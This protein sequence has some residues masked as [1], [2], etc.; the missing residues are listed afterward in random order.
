MR[1]FPFC[2]VLQAPLIPSSELNR[3]DV[4][5]LRP[6]VFS[7]VITLKSWTWNEVMNLPID[8]LA[9]PRSFVFLWCGLGGGVGLDEGRECLRKW[10]F[11]RCEDICWI[12]T[13][14]RLST[15]SISSGGLIGNVFQPT[16]EHCLMG[17]R[18]TVRRGTDD[19]FI[20]ANIDI[21]VLISEQSDRM[22]HE[23]F[24]VIERFCLGRRRLHLFASDQDIRP[25]WVTVGEQ[26]S[27]THF[28]SREYAAQFCGVNSGLSTMT[29]TTERIES[30]RPRSPNGRA[31]GVAAARVA[32]DVGGSRVANTASVQRLLESA[33]A[34]A[35]LGNTIIINQQRENE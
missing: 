8:Q 11:R 3:F 14:K 16:K 27:N 21:D 15:P 13:N 31:V 12:K 29:G 25:G 1:T 30:I 33:A 9:A 6:P 35:N 2:Q 32:L 10:G 34:I 5:L 28:N 23:I 24:G 4:V 26:V 17:I 19:D 20:H 18:G 7:S 22:P